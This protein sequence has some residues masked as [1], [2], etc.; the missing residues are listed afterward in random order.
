[1]NFFCLFWWKNH[2][3]KQTISKGISPKK[4]WEGTIGGLVFA[5]VAAYL[6]LNMKLFYSASTMA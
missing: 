2:R 1:M 3:K 6:S 5:L 4:T